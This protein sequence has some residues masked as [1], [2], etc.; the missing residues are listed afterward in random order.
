MEE[1][2]HT[3]QHVRLRGDMDGIILKHACNLV[4]CAHVWKTSET[5]LC[6][7]H[8]FTSK[9]TIKVTRGP[10]LLRLSDL[11]HSLWTGLTFWATSQL[12]LLP[13]W[14]R[15]THLLIKR[16]RARSPCSD[17][18]AGFATFCCCCF[19]VHRTVQ[20]PEP[21]HWEINPIIRDNW[22]NYFS[23][24]K[25]KLTFWRSIK[26]SVG[27]FKKKTKTL[28]R[29]KSYATIYLHD[30]N[31]C[32]SVSDSVP[33]RFCSFSD[34]CKQTFDY[35]G[36]LSNKGYTS[37]ITVQVHSWD[38]QSKTVAGTTCYT[39]QVIF[40]FSSPFFLVFVICQGISLLQNPGAVCHIN[41]VIKDYFFS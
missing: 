14:C 12:R 35:S 10:C 32:L 40:S 34:Y 31:V 20:Y 37:V 17:W 39:V 22:I 18:S 1:S 4:K 33:P 38:L 28:S 30:S 3:C 7:Q 27:N 26:S 23:H 6:Y 9:I 15:Q 21:F 8:V 36:L 24:P 13:V 11:T 29:F 16:P 25:I 41:T 5:L 2:S 19:N